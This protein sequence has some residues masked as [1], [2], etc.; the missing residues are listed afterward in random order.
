MQLPCTGAPQLHMQLQSTCVS[1][2]P[3]SW[4]AGGERARVGVAT[5]DSSVHFYAIKASQLQPQMLVIPDVDEPYC[6]LP[7]SLLASLQECRRLIDSLLAQIPALFSKS[8]TLDSCGIAALEA[9]IAAL[10]VPLLPGAWHAVLMPM[11]ASCLA[12]A[13]IHW[14]VCACC[15]IPLVAHCMVMLGF[16]Q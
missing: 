13:T 2:R 9:C 5:F 10:K 8:R 3:P 16:S 12:T 4:H 7:G 6:P 14:L 1:L 15:S 11:A